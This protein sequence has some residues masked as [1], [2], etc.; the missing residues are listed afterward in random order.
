MIAWNGEEFVCECRKLTEIK[1][2]SLPVRCIYFL[3][4]VRMNDLPDGYHLVPEGMSISKGY[5]YCE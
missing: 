5:L 3:V 4:N 2:Q 1:R